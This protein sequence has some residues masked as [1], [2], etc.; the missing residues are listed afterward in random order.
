MGERIW[1]EDPK[2]FINAQ[3]A[4]QFFP[5]AKMTLTE[6]LN[7]MVRFALYFTIAVVLVAR[8]F[9]ALYLLLFV[10]AL[11]AF[12]A[13]G[14]NQTTRVEHM[15]QTAADRDCVKPTKNNPFMNVLA[16]EYRDNA[17]RGPACDVLDGKTRSVMDNNFSAGLQR[18]AN[19]IF[20]KSASD[21]QF[22]TTPSTTIPNDQT[23]FAKWLYQTP[24][25]CKEKTLS[26]WAGTHPKYARCG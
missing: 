23:A 10:M 8:K 18:N 11:T 15:T 9:S 12:V 17:K 21:R 13:R 25:T 20:F 1:Y 5:T 14:D 24:P 2:D 6:K 19:D 22:Y 16:N 26:C 3:N 7:S 4:L